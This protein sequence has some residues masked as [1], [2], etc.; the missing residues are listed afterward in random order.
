MFDETNFPYQT[1]NTQ[2]PINV[3][4]HQEVTAFFNE[5]TWQFPEEKSTSSNLKNE[6]KTPT[7]VVH[8][9]FTRK[10]DVEPPHI[11]THT[12]LDLPHID[13]TTHS[14]SRDQINAADRL[15]EQP[16]LDSAISSPIVPSDAQLR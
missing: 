4:Q 6:T 10:F 16:N 14:I 12:P 9:P 2:A 7:V 1:H 13:N 11:D 8:S 15:L 3:E 5:E